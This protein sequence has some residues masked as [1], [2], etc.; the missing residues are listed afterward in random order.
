MVVS[1]LYMENYGTGLCVCLF[2]FSKGTRTQAVPKIST[3]GQF[4]PS[5]PPLWSYASP[6]Q[7]DFQYN[8]PGQ[9][10]ATQLGAATSSFAA[11]KSSGRKKHGLGFLLRSSHGGFLVGYTDVDTIPT[12]E[13]TQQKKPGATLFQKMPRLCDCK[14]F[15]PLS[16]LLI[17]F[18][19][20]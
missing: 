14:M 18:I 10:G 3:T 4:Q 12:P 13:E 7:Q 17:F 1:N 15:Q 5:P 19:R 20:Q 16:F 2:V 8:V 6:T 9:L 11:K